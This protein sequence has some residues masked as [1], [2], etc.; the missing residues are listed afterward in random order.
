MILPD[1]NLLLHAYNSGS[2]VHREAKT[3]WESLMNETRPVGI[4][5]VVILGFV[6]IGTH[7]QILAKPLKIRPSAANSQTQF[8]IV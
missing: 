2:P 8:N 4:P 7:R 6:R 1:L 3:W 5:W